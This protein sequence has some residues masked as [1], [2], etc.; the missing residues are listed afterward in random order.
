MNVRRIAPHLIFA[1]LFSCSLIY[2]CYVGLPV[3]FNSDY[4][5]DNV[6][7]V[8]ETTPLQLVRYVLNPLTP[9]WFYTPRPYLEHI[10]PL[11]ILI[12]HLIHR[13][14][15]FSILP[16][17]VLG[18]LSHGILSAGLWFVVFYWTKRLL[19]AWFAIFLYASFP[20]NFYLMTSS[21]SS[22]FQFFMSVLFLSTL[23]LFFMLS[24]GQFKS[25]R[26]YTIAIM[27][28]VLLIWVAIKLKPSGKFIPFICIGFS[29]LRSRVILQQLGRLRS[30]IL[31]AVLISTMI[32]IVP[33]KPFE[34]WL[35]DMASSSSNTLGIRPSSQ[36]DLRLFSFNLKK[37]LE[38][39]FFQPD[40][41][42]PVAILY[43]KESPRTFTESIGFFLGWF[44]WIGIIL[45]PF[46]LIPFAVRSPSRTN[47][48]DEAFQHYYWILFV[49]FAMILVGFT[50]GVS[51]T[52]IRYL[53]FGYVPF[54]MLF[55]I[56]AYAFETK[57]L[58]QRHLLRFYFRA[59]IAIAILHA[60]ILNFR[61][62]GKLVGHFGGMQSVLVRAE[63]D[64]FQQVYG[65]PP[66]EEIE[67]YDRHQ[68]LERR[69]IV[70]DWYDSMDHGFDEA[71]EKLK[72][73]KMIYFYTRRSDSARLMDFQDVGYSVT[74]W[75]RY[76]FLDS[77][78]IAFKILKGINQIIEKM[79][80]QPLKH[81]ILVYRIH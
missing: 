48:W 43:R 37:G 2:A 79:G 34:A 9:A 44:F 81:E 69:A 32:L 65:R 58:R 75:K 78:P 57:V 38:R 22:D 11:R 63:K 47:E 23:S 41:D 7:S 25:K 30:A 72:R 61:D 10:R 52:D 46:K 42:N 5:D 59:F 56:M 12:F 6:R 66:A 17:Q 20:S 27:T 3:D 14:A 54:V 73:E 64:V 19:W 1:F 49:W 33:L 51:V 16:Y 60:T 55:F 53:D 15:L 31:G 39:I 50:S 36:K 8:R 29:L 4:L 13:W 62:L 28:W 26:S 68:A 35:N 71:I 40:S 80:G 74:L 45:A 76:D 70:V 77:E 67:L 18:A 21:V 24:H